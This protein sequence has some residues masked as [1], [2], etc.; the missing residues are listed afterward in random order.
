MVVE[1]ESIMLKKVDHPCRKDLQ[2]IKK[3]I[4]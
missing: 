3:S 1:K 4:Q 2:S